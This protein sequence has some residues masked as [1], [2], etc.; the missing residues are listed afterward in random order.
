MDTRIKLP[1]SC[2]SAALQ[3]GS[4]LLQSKV[5]FPLPQNILPGGKILLRA[6]VCDSLNFV[7][8]PKVELDTFDNTV[9]GFSCDCPDYRANHR[10]C[11]HCAALVLELAETTGLMQSATAA[12]E[13]ADLSAE[14]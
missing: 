7:D 13:T 3:D 4:K 5:Y 6:K 9:S 2:S 14:T 11:M 10:F 12:Q 8:H 1:E